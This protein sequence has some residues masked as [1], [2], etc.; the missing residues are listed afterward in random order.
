M[1][2]LKLIGL[3]AAFALLIAV[4]LRFD[5]QRIA[6]SLASADS[7]YISAGLILVQVQ[8]VLSALRWRF[9]ATRLGQHLGVG[10]AIGDYYLG[11]LL[12][13]ILPGG[14]AGDAVRA[15]RNRTHDDGGWKVPAQAVLFERIAGQGVFFVIATFG[16]MFWPLLGGAAIPEDLRHLISGFA[17]VA[18]GF[19]VMFLLLLRFPPRRIQPLL[20]ALKMALA[21]VFLRDRAWIVQTLF[22]LVIVASYIAMFMLA[23][24]AVG[25]P[26]PALAAVT[27]IPLCLLMMLIPAT[28]A[29]WGARE[30]AAAALWPLFG[31]A[32]S[33]GVAA[34]I[35]YGILALVGA[36]PG[37]AF[38]LAAL[39]S[40]R[41]R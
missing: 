24:A 5:P 28:I 23:S 6:A 30:A 32:A 25:A 29:G 21:Q 35:L 33:D 19:A 8:I 37:L 9:T 36:A 15:V 12:N 39:F 31:Y 41:N 38:I 10:K 4:I 20:A 7:T 40:S 22:S 34:S 16:V 18:A 27:A 26:L 14:V 11:T 3:S 13:Q 17:L 1:R 2:F